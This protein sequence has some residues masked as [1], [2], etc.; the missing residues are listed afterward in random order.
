MALNVKETV[1]L[2]PRNDEE[3]LQI[4]KI[5]EAAGI[6]ALVSHQPHGARLAMEE[7]LLER[8]R[9]LNSETSTIVIVEIPGVKEEKILEAEGFS[10]I[11]IDHHRYDDLDRMKE[12]SSL[13]QFLEVFDIDDEK[14]LE[15][16]F[17]PLLVRGVGMIDRGFLWELKK[18]GLSSDEQKRVREYYLELLNELGGLEKEAVVE[19]KR[20]WEAREERD[21]VVIIRSLRNDFHIREAF[22]FLMADLF[23]SPP[24]CLIIEGNGRIS[25]Q[26]TDA[27]KALHDKFGGYTFGKDR[28]WGFWP[29]AE[30]P[31]P[32]VEEILSVATGK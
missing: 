21:D 12:K 28:C 24:S 32:S 18:E 31:A 3:S 10:V 14:L 27:A 9:S 2:V 13:E 11:I 26:D 5:A 23:E 19:A 4:G 1:L 15:L 8:V 30:N 20:A 29:T 16:G 6:P 22:S 7:N 17:E 25:F